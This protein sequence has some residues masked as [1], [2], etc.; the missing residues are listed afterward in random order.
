VTHVKATATAAASATTRTVNSKGTSEPWQET[1]GRRDWFVKIPDPDDRRDN[2]GR[3]V[4]KRFRAPTKKAVLAKR[5][6]YLRKRHQ[7]IEVPKGRK[8]MRVGEWMSHWLEHVVRPHIGPTTYNNYKGTIANHILPRLG[9]V[10]LAD[11]STT[12]LEV[13]RDERQAEIAAEEASRAQRAG[14]PI[15]LD[16]GKE[17]ITL[18][19]KRLSAAFDV[20]VKR[21]AETG[22]S[23]NPAADRKLKPRS[24]ESKEARKANPGETL[25][26]IAFARAEGGRLAALVEVG[27][28]LGLRRSELAGLQWQDVDF[29]GRT[30]TLQR[31]V[32]PLNQGVRAL[33]GTKSQKVP[34]P[35]VMEMPDS[36]ADALHATRDQLGAYRLQRGKGW[37]AKNGPLDPEGWVFPAL[38]GTVVHPGMLAE[39]FAKLCQRAGVKNKTLHTL[40]HDFASYLLDQGDSI[41]EVQQAMRHSDPTVTARI[42]AHVLEGRT[43]KAANRMDEA[44]TLYWKQQEE[45][46]G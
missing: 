32:V 45:A 21:R 24:T 29:A 33:P 15:P 8:K 10:A 42:Y 30:I 35:V 6:D 18:A 34:K 39:W 7:G 17:A 12:M 28:K 11:L 13:W 37:T 4:Y 3:L 38:D 40:R 27:F 1:A 31:H 19:I 25:R 22:M 41:A 26:L 14:R 20:A 5:D 9:H 16:A 2:Q 43:R 44:E 46:T 36:V 23:H